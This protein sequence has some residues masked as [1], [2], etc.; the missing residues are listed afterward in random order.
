MISLFPRQY[1][2]SGFGVA[3]NVSISLFGGTTPIVMMWLVNTTSNV[4]SPAWYY[5]FGAIL[6]LASI[7]ICEQGRRRLIRL[8]SAALTY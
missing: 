5:M 4:I 8:E 6:G 7:I 3:F 1:R 2:Y